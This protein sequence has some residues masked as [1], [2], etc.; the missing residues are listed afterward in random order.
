MN[1]V[2]AATDPK[3]DVH[4][5]HKIFHTFRVLITAGYYLLVAFP[6][7]V[8]A[9]QVTLEWDANY[10]EPDGYNLYLRVEGE[11]YDYNNP[12]NEYA[13]DDTTIT[14]ED[15]EEGVR[16]FFVVTAFVGDDESGDSNEVE[17][18]VGDDAGY[19]NSNSSISSTSGNSSDNAGSG[20]FIGISGSQNTGGLRHSIHALI[21]GMFIVV[22]MFFKGSK[23]KTRQQ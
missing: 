8:S 22:A 3:G 19:S 1:A 13:I 11:S 15:L 23:N 20:C 10:P 12:I 4:M 18:M 6:L 17:F 7:V 5:T 2:R 21:V 9:A 16:Y 14:V